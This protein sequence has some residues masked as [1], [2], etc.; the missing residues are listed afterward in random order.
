MVV[1]V[2]SCHLVVVVVVV[3]VSCLVCVVSVVVVFLDGENKP[4]TKD[5]GIDVEDNERERGTD[6]ENAV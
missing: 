1:V 5:R 2:V 6:I 4:W 3:A